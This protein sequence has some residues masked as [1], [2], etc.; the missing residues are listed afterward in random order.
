MPQAKRVVFYVKFARRNGQSGIL[1]EPGTNRPQE[2]FD[3]DSAKAVAQEAQSRLLAH[4]KSTSPAGI[5]RVWIFKTT[6]TVEV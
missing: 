1:C 2:Y 4:K 3:V 5:E 6:K